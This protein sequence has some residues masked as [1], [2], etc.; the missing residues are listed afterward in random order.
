MAIQIKAAY[1]NNQQDMQAYVDAASRTGEPAIIADALA[2]VAKAKGM[3][4]TLQPP[5][6]PSLSSL[7][8]LA[9]VLGVAVQL[10]INCQ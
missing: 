10:G 2:V 8:A 7:I 5:H 9:N 1:L 6:N 3:A 4:N